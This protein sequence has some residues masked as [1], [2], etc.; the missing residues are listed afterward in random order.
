MDGLASYIAYPLPGAIHHSFELHFRFIPMTVDQ[1]ALM[2]FIGQG[3]PHEPSADHLAVS[4]IKGYVVLT[5]NLGSGSHFKNLIHQCIL[6]I[7]NR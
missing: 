3:H 2:V 7:F 5:W 6:Q 4:F 1:I